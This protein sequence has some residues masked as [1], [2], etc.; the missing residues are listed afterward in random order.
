VYQLDGSA[1]LADPDTVI[2]SLS[3]ERSRPRD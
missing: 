1:L 3:G 2:G